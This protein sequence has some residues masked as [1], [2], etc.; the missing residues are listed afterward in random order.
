MKAR[1]PL[2]GALAAVA[3]G[4]LLFHTSLSIPI[5]H[6]AAGY[7][8]IGQQI[9]A[10]GLFTQWE[11]SDLRTWA[12]PTF[13]GGLLKLA[14]STGIA[15][16][17]LVFGVQLAAHLA[18]VFAL[19][20][21]LHRAGIQRWIADSVFYVLLIHP[22]ALIYPS[23][24][25]TESLS[26]SLGT[27]VLACAIG[28]LSDPRRQVAIA[29]V[30]GLLCG[31]MIAVRPAS[32]FMV[33]ALL[34]AWVAVWFLRR[35]AGSKMLGMVAAGLLCFSLPLMPQLRNNMVYYGKT[36]VLVAAPFAQG[37]Q[38]IGIL[39]LKYATSIEPHQDP[40]IKYLNPLAVD[41]P[42][43]AKDPTAWYLRYPGRGVVTIAIHAFNLLDQDLPLPYNLTL[44]PTY[45][46]FVSIANLAIVALGLAGLGVVVAG[47][48]RRSAIEKWIIVIA[49]VTL[50]CHL[51]LHSLFSVEA[52]YGVFALV[53]LY[54]FAAICGGWLIRTAQNRARLLVSAF[55]VAFCVGGYFLSAWVRW[56]ALPIRAEILA[57][58]A[59]GHP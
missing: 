52:R 34:L 55:V 24:M 14:Q 42:L 7:H 31:F 50:V 26:I 17:W 29:A 58:S 38:Y 54:A 49:V 19:R 8:R 30:G 35:P 53:L 43:A 9:W 12:Y 16:R 39:W 57:A 45:Y 13:L 20:A 25:L 2:L 33:P 4:L 11:L 3:I 59:Q 44:I 56:Q 46:P 15:E 47:W 27:A 37:Q 1:G 10:Q 22:F 36:T 18:S 21:A 23:Y 51:G 41:E 40:Q 5:I 32:M 28:V 48:P 6:D